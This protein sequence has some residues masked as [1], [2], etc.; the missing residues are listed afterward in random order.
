M[1]HQSRFTQRRVRQ[2]PDDETRLVREMIGLAE[3]YGLYGYR[4]IT[5][6]LRRK[7]WRVSHKRIEGLWRREGLKVIQ[8]Q[9]KR[10]GLWLNDGPCVRLW[11]SHRD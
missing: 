7:G 9:P 4:R 5:V 3:Q 2:V 10:R 6:M 8:R 11:P 1:L